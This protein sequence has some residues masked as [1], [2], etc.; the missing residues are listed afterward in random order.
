MS[1]TRPTN[2]G[3]AL[4][5]AAVAKP[6]QITRQ[7]F[8]AQELAFAAETTTAAAAATAKALVEA[9]FV[10]ALRKPRDWD[11]VEQRLLRAIERPGFAGKSGRDTGPGEA[12]YRK[13]IGKGGV[14]GFSIRFAEEAM[15]CMGNIDARPTVVYEDSEKRLVDVMVLDLESNIAFTSTVVVPKTVERSWLGEGEVP[16]RTRMNSKNKPVYLRAATDDEITVTQNALVS[17]VLRNEI[18]R[19]LPGDIQAT[20][21]RRILE[22]RQGD[23]ATNPDGV[24]KEILEAFAK[25]NVMPASLKQWLGHELSTATPAELTDLREL[26]RAI[27]KGE[28]TWHDALAAALAERGEETPPP[29][30]AVGAP[31]KNL[32]Q[33]TDQMKAAGTPPQPPADPAAASDADIDAGR[34]PSASAPEAEE[35]PAGKG[36]QRRLEE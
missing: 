1:E 21:R 8:G 15:R 23:A 29:P 31:A 35:K 36:R 19:I 13:P 30:P 4:A 10:M 32:D 6:G 33:L 22:I 17:K 28:T 26:Y 11:D 2:G 18:L 27:N 5:P 25:L 14:E 24:K 7:E 12:W 20:C 16:L 3:A 9:R 34:P